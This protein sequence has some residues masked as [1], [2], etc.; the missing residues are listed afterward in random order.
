MDNMKYQEVKGVNTHLVRRHHSLRLRLPRSKHPLQRLIDPQYLPS[1]MGHFHL[2][3]SHNLAKV[4]W[5][6]NSMHC[7]VTV[8]GFTIQ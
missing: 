4:E 6:N 5:Q 1:V 7:I 2:L 3:H 8:F